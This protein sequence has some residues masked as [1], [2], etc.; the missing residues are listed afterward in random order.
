MNNNLDKTTHGN[1]SNTLSNKK[2]ALFIY[3]AFKQFRFAI[4]IM[5][6]TALVWALDLSLRPYLLKLIIDR[7]SDTSNHDIFKSVGSLTMIYFFMTFLYASIGRFYGYFVEIKMI[8]TMRR[9]IANI[10]FSSLLQQSYSYYQNNFAGS[11]TN[12]VND[13]T[14]SVPDIIQLAI[15][16]FFSHS[17]ALL[18]A[19]ITLWQVNAI[20]AL[21][22]LCWSVIF[23]G[24][25]LFLSKKLSHLADNWSES[26]S[27]ITGTMVDSLSNILAIRLFARDKE[28][29]AYLSS[30]FNNAANA[31]KKLQWAYFWIWFFYGYSFVIVQGINLYF[32]LKLV[33]SIYS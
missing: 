17:I 15:D 14:S 13:L 30:I 11:L 2:V 18:I 1:S 10:S 6:L 12:K 27:T 4:C 32:L 26:A 19:I 3:N 24:G 20:F 16:R 33:R 8:P 9:T 29:K 5:L 21:G 25:S 28:E 22:M 23:I 7:I 31:E